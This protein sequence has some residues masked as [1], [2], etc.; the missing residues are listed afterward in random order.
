MMS[1]LSARTCGIMIIVSGR[2]SVLSDS[3]LVACK[4][5]ADAS[6]GAKGA[7]AIVSLNL[8]EME[9]VFGSLHEM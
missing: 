9:R 4:K 3:S 6:A 8:W 1:L 2:H 7:S 5:H